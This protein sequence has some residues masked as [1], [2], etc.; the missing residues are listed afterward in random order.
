VYFVEPTP[1]GG[2]YAIGHDSLSGEIRTLKL[3]R[4]QKVQVLDEVFEIPPDFDAF[5][6][7]NGLP[8]PLKFLDGKPVRS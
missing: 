4:M 8:D 5:P 6:K 1:Q 3:Q 2:L 7:V